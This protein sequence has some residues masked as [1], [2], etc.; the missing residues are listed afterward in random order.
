[1]GKLMLPEYFSLTH[2]VAFVD[3]KGTLII[4]I[5]FF[6]LWHFAN[7]ALVSSCYHNYLHEII[8]HQS[9]SPTSTEETPNG[10]MSAKQENVKCIH[11]RKS[12]N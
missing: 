2:V 5:L 9:S 12:I 1:M 3:F 11:V 4:C 10:D 7:I 8:I 6:H